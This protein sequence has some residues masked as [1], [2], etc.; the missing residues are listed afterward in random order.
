[1][2]HTS[3]TVMRDRLMPCIRNNYTSAQWFSSERQKEETIPDKYAQFLCFLSSDLTISPFPTLQFKGFYFTF[4][5]H[6][7]YRN[8]CTQQATNCSRQLLFPSLQQPGSAEL[9]VWDLRWE[10]SSGSL[11]WRRLRV[12]GLE[13]GWRTNA[14]WQP[15]VVS[16]VLQVSVV[17]TLAEVL[18]SA[19]EI[20]VSYGCFPIQHSWNSQHPWSGSRP[21]H[22]RY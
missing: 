3:Q 12:V 6:S 20:Q 11:L 21:H 2:L 9:Q 5:P 19:I 1:M 13:E 16:V 10:R 8:I 18:P 17:F 7:S 14:L 4:C 15:A 22:G